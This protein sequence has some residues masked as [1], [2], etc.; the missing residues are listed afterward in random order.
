MSKSNQIIEQRHLGKASSSATQSR[1]STGAGHKQQTHRRRGVCVSV[2]LC[3]LPAYLRPNSLNNG[4][5]NHDPMNPNP[6]CRGIWVQ[7]GG[8]GHVPSL[9]RGGRRGS[10]TAG[11]EQARRQRASWR[12]SRRRRRASWGRRTRRASASDARTRKWTSERLG[13]PVSFPSANSQGQAGHFA[14]PC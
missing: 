6:K 3:A 9:R 10:G 12:R 5:L 2:T 4:P 8:R 11:G 14:L 7:R 13:R 1:T